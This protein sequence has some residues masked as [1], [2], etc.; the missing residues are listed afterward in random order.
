MQYKLYDCVNGGW[1][2]SRLF[3]E[4]EAKAYLLAQVGTDLEQAFVEG[5]FF[6]APADTDEGNPYGGDCLELRDVSD[7]A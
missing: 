5:G 6:F 3:D 7:F 2:N 1:F 4:E